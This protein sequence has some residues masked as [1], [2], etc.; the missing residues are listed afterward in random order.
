MGGTSFG[1][2]KDF[3]R[4]DRRPGRWNRENSGG[5]SQGRVS[6]SPI[7][8]LG[9]T[10]LATSLML[11]AGADDGPPAKTP[12]CSH[13]SQAELI[14]GPVGII[15]PNGLLGEVTPH[16]EAWEPPPYPKCCSVFPQQHNILALGGAQHAAKHE[17]LHSAAKELLA[18]YDLRREYPPNIT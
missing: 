9:T 11:R 10:Q 13:V 17:F 14:V 5:A 7:R 1:K 2:R 3:D 15:M 18:D 4:S 6:Q 16:G 8:A 12:W